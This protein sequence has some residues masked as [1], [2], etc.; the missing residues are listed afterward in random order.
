MIKVRPWEAL[1][2]NGSKAGARPI[3]LGW[4]YTSCVVDMLEDLARSRAVIDVY[5]TSSFWEGVL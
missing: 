5:L 3:R 1:R 2:S 4:R